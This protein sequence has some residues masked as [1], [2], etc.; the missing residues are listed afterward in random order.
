VQKRYIG[1]HPRGEVGNTWDQDVI[2]IPI[3]GW[4]WEADFA[5]NASDVTYNFR[6]ARMLSSVLE[7]IYIIK[8]IYICIIEKD[9]FEKHNLLLNAL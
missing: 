4:F 9:N 7:Y 8:F 2:A 1:V 6:E 3:S 5:C